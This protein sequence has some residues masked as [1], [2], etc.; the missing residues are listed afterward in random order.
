VEWIAQF[1][2]RVIALKDGR[3]FLDGTPSAVLTSSLLPENGF[4][5]SR[6]TSVARKAREM[7]LWKQANLPVTL[8]EAV[9]GFASPRPVERAG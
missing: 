3:I 7:G 9:E 2:D 5:I 6:Y 1:A 4:G 8:D